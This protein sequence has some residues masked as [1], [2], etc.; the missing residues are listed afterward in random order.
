VLSWLFGKKE[1]KPRVV[2]KIVQTIDVDPDSDVVI[3]NGVVM[4]DGELIDLKSR[5]DL[6][7][8]G[9]LKSL[10]LSGGSISMTGRVGGD[11]NCTGGSV[12]CNE[13]GRNINCKGDLNCR[14]VAGE[15]RCVGDMVCDG[16]YNNVHVGG[17]FNCKR[18]G[19]NIINKVKSKNGE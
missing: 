10:T 11:L 14:D 1:K 12:S 19:G 5:S 8:N 4:I 13:V 2:T 15:V 7:I 3:D 9:N 16:V 6:T 18:V 17:N